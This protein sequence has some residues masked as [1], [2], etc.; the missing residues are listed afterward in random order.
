MGKGIN[1]SK[2]TKTLILSKVSQVT[3]FST[4]LN[5]S[6]SMIQYCIETGELILSPIREDYHPTVGFRY[7]NKGRLKMK[8]FAGYFWGD[9]FDLVALIISSIYKENINISNKQDF[10]RVL[11]HIALTFK[12]I[13]YGQSK[14]INLIKE[15]NVSL[16]II[17]KRKP[18]IDLVT[19][20]WNMLDKEY[21]G[22]FRVPLQYLNTH[23]IYPI[24]QYYVDMK[25]NPTPKYYYAQD[26]P[27]YAYLLGKDRSGVNDIKLYFPY[28]DKSYTRF[29]TNCN[30]FEGVYNLER[31]DYNIIIITKSTKDRV[32]L[33]A[34]LLNILS[35]YRE[36]DVKI[37][38]IN[39]PHETYKLRDFEYTWLVTKLANKG[40]IVSLMDNDKVGKVQA[41]WLRD[42]FR[43]IPI[44]IPKK[45]NAK[46][47][48]ELVERNSFDTVFKLVINTIKNII[49]YARE[50]NKF[51]RDTSEGDTAPF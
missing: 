33:G 18:I 24:D 1:N 38:V 25:V 13:F 3:I 47:F 22:K 10:I 11:Q 42:I 29:I 34:N 26:D 5:I 12:D 36:L 43:I 2:L 16:D 15:I 44:L 37:G 45:Y 4:Y 31:N 35:L 7:D 20:P 49:N 8:D 19:R 48:A 39:I 6:D 51:A 21:W 17:K 46:D 27:C 50:N 41:K 30:H 40:I 32:C 14:D 28:R 23:F 9:C